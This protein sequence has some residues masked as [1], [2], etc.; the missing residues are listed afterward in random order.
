MTTDAMIDEVEIVMSPVDIQLANFDA[1]QS[2]VY[3]RGRVFVAAN[4]FFCVRSICK[5]KTQTVADGIAVR[6]V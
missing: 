2:V 6:F 4:A 5:W 3:V 1:G